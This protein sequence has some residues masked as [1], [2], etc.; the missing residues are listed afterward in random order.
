MDKLNFHF[1]G[2]IMTGEISSDTLS[3]NEADGVMGYT[4]LL[5]QDVIKVDTPPILIEQKRMG[6]FTA[7]KIML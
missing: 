7:R 3:P 2:K 4:W 1:E 5:Q 6:K